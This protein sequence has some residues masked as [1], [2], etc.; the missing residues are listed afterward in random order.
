VASAVPVFAEGFLDIYAGSSFTD[1]SQVKLVHNDGTVTSADMGFKSAAIYGIRGGAWLRSLPWL[2]VGGDFSSLHTRGHDTNIDILP[3]TPMV[4]F[5]LPLLADEEIP[6]GW[7]QPYAGIGPSFALYTYVHTSQG[8]PTNSISGTDAGGAALGF[9]LPAGLNIQLSRHVALF[10]E[11]RFAF[12]RMD[13][14]R[15]FD[16]QGLF[17]SSNAVNKNVRTDLFMNNVLAG[18]SF[19]F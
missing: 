17:V 1:N 6:Q 4:Y 15:D 18:I 5:R 19:H 7:L 11:Y 16:S 13:V 12:Y 14:R 2:G 10:T 8:A 9:Q 3:L